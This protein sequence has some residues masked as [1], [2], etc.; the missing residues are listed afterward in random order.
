MACVGRVVAPYITV[1]EAAGS[2]GIDAQ[3]LVRD[4]AQAA[5]P[6]HNSVPA[7]AEPAGP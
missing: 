2:Y 6:G 5:K 4:L 1:R 7:R 3:A